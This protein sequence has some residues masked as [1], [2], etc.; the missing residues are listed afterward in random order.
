MFPNCFVS[1][2]LVLVSLQTCLVSTCCNLSLVYLTSCVNSCQHKMCDTAH[3]LASGGVGG[4]C[5]MFSQHAQ[6]NSLN[7]EKGGWC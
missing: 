4:S 1:N 3:Y 6:R 2:P 5:I 7:G